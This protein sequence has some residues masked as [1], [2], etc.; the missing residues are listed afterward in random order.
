MSLAEPLLEAFALFFLINLL[1]V[2]P[3]FRDLYARGKKPLSCDVCMAFWAVLA[4][5]LLGLY[6]FHQYAFLADVPVAV[7]AAGGLLA[8]LR[9][10]PQTPG[11]PPALAAGD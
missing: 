1:R 9:L 2:L 3:L 10:F 6:V 4:V 8:L 11:R 5:A 7:P